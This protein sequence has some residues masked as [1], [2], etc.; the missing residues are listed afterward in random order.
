M[1]QE[2]IVGMI[3]LSFISLF[4]LIWIGLSALEASAFNAVTGKHVTTWQAMWIDLRV[5]ETAK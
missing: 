1:N 4:V 2:K 3:M 5:V